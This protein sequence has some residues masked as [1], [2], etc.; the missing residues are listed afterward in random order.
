MWYIFPKTRNPLFVDFWSLVVWS[1]VWKG[2]E[3]YENSICGAHQCMSVVW[4]KHGFLNS[5]L[6]QFESLSLPYSFVHLFALFYI[7]FIVASRIPSFPQL[8]S[9][10]LIAP[11][12]NCRLSYFSWTKLA[13]F[14]PNIICRCQSWWKTTAKLASPSYIIIS[15]RKKRTFFKLPLRSQ[16]I[17]GDQFKISTESNTLRFTM[18]S[19]YDNSR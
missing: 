14:K 4:L 13:K 9:N 8:E 7:L 15:I 2:T 5:P 3:K 6:L 16:S 10:R 18:E 17:H 11:N 19:S 1:Q 12:H